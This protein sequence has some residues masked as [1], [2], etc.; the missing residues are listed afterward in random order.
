MY[1][2]HGAFSTSCYLPCPLRAPPIGLLGKVEILERRVFTKFTKEQQNRIIKT[3]IANRDNQR[4]GT[5]G[6]NTTNDSVFLLSLEEMIKYFVDSGQLRNKNP[7]SQ[8]FIDDQYNS[9]RITKGTNGEA[10]WWW[11]RS[12]GDRSSAVADVRSG[13]GAYVDDIRANNDYSGVRP[14]LWLNLKQAI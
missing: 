12:P 5:K 7:K 9:A 3:Q 2:S 11:L 14:A 1:T 8:H 4:Y 13:G 6:G 10:R